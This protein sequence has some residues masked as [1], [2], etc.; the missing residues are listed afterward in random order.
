MCYAEL[1]AVL[2][3]A[4]WPKEAEA[5]YLSA[6]ALWK[7]LADSFRDRPNFR[8]ELARTYN[9][10]GVLRFTTGRAGEAEGPY[11]DALKVWEQ[12]VADF[13]SVP[14]YQN[15]MTGA[16][17]NL[18]MVYNQ[19]R[20]FAAAVPFLEKARPHHEAALKARP[21]N[22]TYCLFYRNN[23]RTLAQSY[24]GLG[25]HA[26]I[27]TSADEMARFAFDPADDAYTAASFL[28]R[29]VTLADKDGKLDENKRKEL[30]K[31]YA[32]RAVALLQ[33]AV[34]NG[35]R[36]AAH[37]RQNPDLQPLRGRD[38]F[39]QLLSKLEGKTKK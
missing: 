34:V 9:S 13:A 37:M 36:N 11:R 10:L 7:R 3:D 21:K 1:A 39:Q 18:A 17:V 28:S 6:V 23:L 14:D 19:R 22:S 5:A 15:G 16:L 26:R 33:K 24:L 35:Y 38:D 31:T 12:L 4:R 29:C 32:D 2:G 30:A 27:A 20:E 8:Q 25:D